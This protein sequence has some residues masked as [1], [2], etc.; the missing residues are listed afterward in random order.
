MT[1]KRIRNVFALLAIAIAVLA[2]T[3]VTAVALVSDN[4]IPGVPLPASPVSGSLTDTTV[5]GAWDYDDVFGVPLARNERLEVTMTPPATADFDLYLFSYLTKTLDQGFASGT[6][7]I[8]AMSEGLTGATEHLNFVSD[9]STVTTYYLDVAA[10]YDSSGPYTLWW[11]KT[12]L[13][14][15]SIDITAPALSGGYSVAATVSGVATVALT[16]ESS[17][18]PMS[19][20][21]VYIM[22]KP[23]GSTTWTKVATTKTTTQGAFAA[24]VRPTRGTQYYAKTPWAFSS[25]DSAPIGFGASKAVTILPKA[26]LAFSTTPKVA[27]A[28]HAFGVTGIVKPSHGYT[29]RHIKVTASKYNGTRYVY[30]KYIWA[31]GSGGSFSGK[32]S[33]P[34]GRWRLSLSAAA[35]SLHASTTSTSFRYLS[36]R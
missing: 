30:Y 4:D 13:P 15:P 14:S 16:P 5:V 32:L 17:A 26:Y 3:V 27:Y 25:E 20:F 23:A 19:G 18:R 28:G 9:R 1:S 21:T 24:I 34:K 22:A 35:D 31:R 7:L 33:L 11:T 6:S 10:Q 36:V 12:Q 29:S 8:S 2:L